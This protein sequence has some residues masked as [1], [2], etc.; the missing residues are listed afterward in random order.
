MGL[1]VRQVTEFRLALALHNDPV[2]RDAMIQELA[3]DLAKDALQLLVVD[4]DKDEHGRML[5]EHVKLSLTRLSP[6]MRP[7]VMVVNLEGRVEYNPELA[8][9]KHTDFLASANLH[10]EL[11]V[12]ACPCPLVIWMTEMLEQAFVKQAPD[13]W[14]WR[15]HVFDLRTRRMSQ[16]QGQDEEGVLIGSDDQ[17]IHPGVRVT[18]LLEELAAYRA[19]GSR[20]DEMRTLNAIGIARQQMGDARLARHDFQAV[21]EIAR[22]LQA[23]GWEATALGNLGGTLAE[24]GDLELAE[25]SF[26]QALEI[27]RAVQDL[28]MEANILSNLGIIRRRMN[29][30]PK[31]LEYHEQSL[32]LARLIKDR[33]TEGTALANLANV[34]ADLHDDR[35][36]IELAEESLLIAREL[37]DRRGEAGALGTL[38]VTHRHLGDLQ[39][40][41]DY[42]S[43]QEAISREVGDWR[44]E[45]RAI[46][47][48]A[49]A[50]GAMGRHEEG[51]SL[52]RNALVIYKSLGHPLARDIEAFLNE[53]EA[54]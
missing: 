34:H 43:Q 37:G 7:V 32:S 24:I 20:F 5:L 52:A 40:A 12:A 25:I 53:L 17:R 10:R 54:A 28:K 1:F 16:S 29:D 13:L 27:A 23:P 42:Y 9:A 31:A 15:S 2:R 50:H 41:I 46:W 11:F 18:K 44:G 51:R 30:L 6:G 49:L 4:L 8:A 26:A 36:A 3:G 45:G 47:N 19:N 21:F 14:H 35:K 48:S 38:G 22:E 39:K 33:K